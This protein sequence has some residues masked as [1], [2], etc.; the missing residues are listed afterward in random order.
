MFALAF[1]LFSVVS[2]LWTDTKLSRVLTEKEKH[3]PRGDRSEDTAEPRGGQ[4]KPR[5]G[6][7]SL[8]RAV[9]SLSYSLH[10]GCSHS[11]MFSTQYLM[12]IRYGLQLLDSSCWRVLYFD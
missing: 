2:I 6:A 5:A 3:T 4:V 12:S 8:F 9:N 1:A 10:P 7:S 11:L